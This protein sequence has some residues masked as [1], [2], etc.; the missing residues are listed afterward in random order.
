MSNIQ[1]YLIDLK[2][3]NPDAISVLFP[4]VRDNKNINNQYERLL[5][6]L[7]ITDTLIA[8]AKVLD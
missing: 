1:K 8:T 3:I 6:K 5:N 7:N 4:R 2:I